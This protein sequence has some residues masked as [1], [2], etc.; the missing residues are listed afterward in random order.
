MNNG[1]TTVYQ[2]HHT[3][4]NKRG[5]SIFKDIRGEFL[6]TRIGEGKKV[7]DIGCRDGVLTKQ[8]YLNNEVLGVDIDEQALSDLKKEI[9]IDVKKM[10]LNGEWDLEKNYYDFVVA[11]EVIEHLYYPKEVCKKISM[12]LK[13]DGKLLGSV[14]NAFNLKNRIRL[15]FGK[16]KNT[17][18][19]DPTHINHFTRKELE[20]ILKMYFEKVEITPLGKYAFLDKFFPG[21]FSFM[22]LFEA[23]SKKNHERLH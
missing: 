22:F 19:S 15:F 4:L 12:V 5:I 18:L 23:S 8:Y 16:K 10:D 1:L 9:Q 13:K 20:E 17:P 7:L 11:G 14:P 3:D 21:V 2:K 6:K